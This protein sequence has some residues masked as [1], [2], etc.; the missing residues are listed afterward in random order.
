MHARSVIFT[1]ETK[2]SNERPQER[3]EPP[4]IE[5]CKVEGCQR[6]MSEEGMYYR[7]YSVCKA[8]LRSLQL[9]VDGRIQRFCQQ[10][11]KFQDIEEFDEEKRSCR[12]QLE[13]HSRRRRLK[14][15]EQRLQRQQQQLQQQQQQQEQQQRINQHL[16]Q[17]QAQ[18]KPSGSA[19]FRSAGSGGTAAAAELGLDDGNPHVA[20]T[21]PEWWSS[22]SG[23]QRDRSG[24]ARP[25]TRTKSGIDDTAHGSGNESQFC[26]DLKQALQEPPQREDTQQLGPLVLD[27]PGAL[28]GNGLVSL[29]RRTGGSG[30]AQLATAI[31]VDKGA[32]SLGGSGS[33]RPPE[34]PMRQGGTL[35]PPQQ[36]SELHH[37][38]TMASMAACQSPAAEAPLERSSA[39]ALSPP[40][41]QPQQQPPQKEAPTRAMSFT[42]PEATLTFSLSGTTPPLRH[43]PPPPP[44]PPQQPQQPQQQQGYQ[45]PFPSAVQSSSFPSTGLL[46]QPPGAA[47]DLTNLHIAGP[48]SIAHDP[49]LEREL[50]SLLGELV[51]EQKRFSEAYATGSMVATSTMVVGAGTAGGGGVWAMG[52][53]GSDRTGSGSGPSSGSELQSV[54]LGQPLRQPM[55]SQPQLLPMS[56]TAASAAGGND[57]GPKDG[58]GGWAAGDNDLQAS[59]RAIWTLSNLHTADFSA[60]EAN[61]LQ[62]NGDDGERRGTGQIR[63]GEMSGSASAPLPYLTAAIDAAT[64]GIS[65]MDWLPGGRGRG[66][67]HGNIDG[68]QQQLGLQ[69]SALRLLAAPLQ[70][71]PGPNVAGT[72]DSSGGA[73]LYGSG[74]SS[75]H[76]QRSNSAAADAHLGLM[77]TTA[78]LPATGH[79]TADVPM[80]S[81]YLLEPVN[82]D[83]QQ[84]HQLTRANAQLGSD[85]HLHEQ[86]PPSDNQAPIQRPN[87]PPS[88]ISQVYHP[89]GSGAVRHTAGGLSLG[90]PTAGVFERLQ[91]QPQQPLQLPVQSIEQLLQRRGLQQQQQQVTPEHRAAPLE[92]PSMTMATSLLS[93]RLLQTMA[94]PVPQGLAMPNQLQ[95]QHNCQAYQPPKQLPHSQVLDQQSNQHSKLL[96]IAGANPLAPGGAAGA[97][98]PYGIGNSQPVSLP[99]NSTQLL[100]RL[101]FK[102]HGCSPSDLMPDSRARL[103]SWL[104]SMSLQMLQYTTRSGCTLIIADVLIPAAAANAANANVN[105]ARSS[106]PN[107]SLLARLLECPTGAQGLG[108]AEAATAMLPLPPLQANDKNV[109]PSGVVVGPSGQPHPVARFPEVLSLYQKGSIRPSTATDI[110]NSD[111]GNNADVE[112]TGH[113]EGHGSALALA[114]GVECTPTSDYTDRTSDVSTGSSTGTENDGSGI[115]GDSRHDTCNTPCKLSGEGSLGRDYTGCDAIA[116]KDPG[117]MEGWR[118]PIER[119]QQQL[120]VP[121]GPAAAT[122]ADVTEATASTATGIS[123]AAGAPPTAGA[124]RLMGQVGGSL[125]EL[126]RILLGPLV[127]RPETGQPASEEGAVADQPL[128]LQLEDQV[129]CMAWPRRVT[130]DPR[131][132]AAKGDGKGNG[133]G[134]PARGDQG[135]RDPGDLLLASIEGDNPGQDRPEWLENAGPWVMPPP[136]MLLSLQPAAVTAGHASSLRVTMRLPP[137]LPLA[138]ALSGAHGFG[139]VPAGN[140]RTGCSR[141]PPAMLHL[142]YGGACV[143]SCQ[144]QPGDLRPVTSGN[145]AFIEE[146]GTQCHVRQQRQ[147]PMPSDSPPDLSPVIQTPS[148]SPGDIDLPEQPAGSSSHQ[149]SLTASPMELNVVGN[150]RPASAAEAPRIQMASVSSLA[151][152]SGAAGA[153]VAASPGANAEAGIVAEYVL[154]VPSLAAPGLAFVETSCGDVLGPWLPLP[155]VPSEAAAAEISSLTYERSLLRPF[156]CDMGRLLMLSAAGACL[157]E[158]GYTDDWD[159]YEAYCELRDSIPD[160][161][162]VAGRLLRQCIEWH[163]PECTTLSTSLF[164]ELVEGGPP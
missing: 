37:H 34:W 151:D 40:K 23:L 66:S 51:D 79:I 73:A 86:L 85:R 155:V 48:Q 105:G 92:G 102:L 127:V 158:S 144:V 107:R 120:A 143:L 56:L 3:S 95:L 108:F 44:P 5:I 109:D 91:S 162:V 90:C 153:D 94:P 134:N 139:D 4:E 78:Y 164:L 160:A 19:P 71:P 14:L 135:T 116:G 62:T 47:K 93:S 124:L 43:Q 9:L 41:S 7:R 8:H 45:E 35:P 163:L 152:I 113:S 106:D 146:A 149:W 50:S 123:A 87:V 150:Q 115:G 138:D 157:E 145:G 59:Q 99:Y 64:A 83:Q 70:P 125:L 11:G 68:A 88:A 81:S 27:D 129:V 12:T 75:G 60:G 112:L 132:A 32:F 29:S 121:L 18:P 24:G 117:S 55:R 154:H 110:S 54:P 89:G 39:M 72:L 122:A 133:D 57:S 76:G 13:H 101:S 49:R 96:N 141:D 58:G 97:G 128:L 74:G 22:F 33:A 2:M 159:A 17:P 6:L 61:M 36:R 98:L 80:P 104:T 156:L 84:C 161:E 53:G 103:Q 67:V 52:S 20:T 16:Q 130:S 42:R 26:L 1:D 25:W 131:V 21:M 100:Q 118:S 65:G 147:V 82:L 142:R 30:S 69:G 28:A 136:P 15:A 111:G 10:C 63:S 31:L 119:G 46:L 77:R 137:H 148:V 38:V 140:A 114:F 126:L